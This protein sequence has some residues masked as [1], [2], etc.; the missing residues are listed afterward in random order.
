[1]LTAKYQ[2]QTL[3]GLVK[4]YAPESE[5]DTVAYQKFI[6]EKLGVPGDSPVSKLSAQQLDVLKDAIR[7]F[8]GWRVGQ[9]KP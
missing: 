3:D 9:I 5:N 2:S 8:E 7:Q 4:Q 6:R 1:M